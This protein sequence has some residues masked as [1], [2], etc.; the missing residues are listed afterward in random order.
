[1]KAEAASEPTGWFSRP[2]SDCV[3]L[4]MRS[5]GHINPFG[6]VHGV[7]RAHR[8]SRTLSSSGGRPAGPMGIGMGGS[9]APSS[10]QAR[11][12]VLASM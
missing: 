12:S 9:D 2:W 4:S 1:M 3:T 11:P 5:P 10:F 7:S 8:L 6:K